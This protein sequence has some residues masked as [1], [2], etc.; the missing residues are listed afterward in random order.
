MLEVH[1]KIITKL[2]EMSVLLTWINSIPRAESNV[3]TGVAA[4]S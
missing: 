2:V 1:C 3:G 4:F